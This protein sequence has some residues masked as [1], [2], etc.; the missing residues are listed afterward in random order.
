M[1]VIMEAGAT[2]AQCVAVDAAIQSLGYSSVRVPGA[3]RT[4]ICVVGNKGLV[5]PETFTALPGVKEA[6]AVTRPYKLVSRE[7]RQANTVVKVGEVAI[8][9][10]K[11]VLIVGPCSVETEARTLRIAHAVR[12]AG[13]HLFR[14]GAYKPRSSPYSFQGLGE[15]GLHTLARVREETGMGVVSE[16]V[17]VRDLDAMIEQVDVLQVGTRNMANY[18][19]LKALGEVR[20]PVLLKRGMSATLDEWLMAAEYLLSAGNPNVILCERGIRTFTDHSRNTLDL[21]VVP[22]IRERTHLPILVDPSHGV[23]DSKRVR[24]MARAAL[25]S[26][27]QGLLIEAHTDPASAYSDGHQTLDIE[28]FAGVSRD[29]AVFSELESIHRG[30]SVAGE[31][32]Q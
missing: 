32:A 16:V 10:P 30:E 18:A 19:L 14:A 27:A 8:G 12:E 15:E 24:A 6:M 25:G 17:D 22:L 11:P 23:G 20:H 3:G 29:V 9:G 21:N 31:S 13:A 26:G 28:A 4:A 5:P 7:V 2:E 1:L